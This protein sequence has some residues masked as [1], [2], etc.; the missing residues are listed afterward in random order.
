MNKIS[1]TTKE[2][3]FSCKNIAQ[4]SIWM[5]LILSKCS[6]NDVKSS[7]S[8]IFGGPQTPHITTIFGKN[9]Q[10]ILFYVNKSACHILGTICDTSK[11][12]TLDIVFKLAGNSNQLV[13][14][15][16]TYLMKSRYKIPALVSLLLTS[17][18]ITLHVF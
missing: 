9:L 17:L 16:G 5:I 7:I 18:L 4:I 3:C 8:L 6:I 11:F 1:Q 13:V 2:S 15:N 14:M 12:T 10:T